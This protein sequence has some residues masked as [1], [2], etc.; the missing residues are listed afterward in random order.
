MK[1]LRAAYFI[2]ANTAILFLLIVSITHVALTRYLDYKAATIYRRLPAV[3]QRNYAHMAPAD[4][5]DLLKSTAT[6]RYRFAPWIG[7]KE[8]PTTSRFVNVNE[9]GIRSNGGAPGHRSDIQDAVWFFGGSTTFGYGVADHETI[10]AQLEAALGQPVVNF[11]AAAF[12]SAQENLLLV[13]TL[14]HGFRP[15]RRVVSRRDQ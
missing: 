3:V 8:R 14:R 4:V 1:P 13:Q 2:V 10:P 5:A 6:M 11:G 12:F 15:A 7:M 9:L